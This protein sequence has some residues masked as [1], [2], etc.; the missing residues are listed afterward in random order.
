MP[1]SVGPNTFGEEN[2]VFGYDLGD[3]INS[4]KGQPTTN[5][6]G[7]SFR[8]FTGT[9]YSPDGEWISSEP[10]RF[11][12][13]YFSTLPTPIGPGGTLI[14][15]SGTAGFHHLSRYGGGGEDGLHSLSCYLYPFVA[16]ITDF[17]IGMLGDGSN[18][19]QFNLDTRAITY[20]GGISNRNAFIKN[21]PGWPGWLR[22]GANIEGR[23]GGWVGCLGY[24]SYTS[25]T[26]TA[27]GKKAYIT[28]IQYEYKTQP[29]P[30]TP[31]T[32]SNTQGLIDLFGRSTIDLTNVSFD[33]NAQMEF[34][35]TDDSL[36]VG[37]NSILKNNDTS[38]EFIIKYLNTPNGDIIQFGVGSGTYAQYY[39]RAYSGNSYW[40]FYPAGGDGAG[41]ITIPN[42]ALPLNK[43][44][45]IVMTG[46]AQGYVQF[47]INGIAQ[48]GANRSSYSQ[49]ANWTPADLTVGGFSWDGYSNSEIPYVKIYNRVLSASEIQQNFNAIKGRFSI[50]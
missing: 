17:C 31:G 32:R 13:T 42:A 14:E 23:A 10:T 5:N 35:G 33:G 11:T 49:A 44:H 6:Y 41:D 18:N 45:H 37:N 20:G 29:T 50:S 26:G 25:Y 4:Y 2:L 43:F 21:V 1:T 16:G 7:G 24:S 47:Y 40:N 34:D 36:V 27:G 8:D 15:E 9:S 38:I 48:S 28:G 30:F 19:I 3:V 39:Y 46:N 22:V 12:K